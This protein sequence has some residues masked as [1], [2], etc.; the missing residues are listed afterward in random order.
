[1]G[2]RTGINWK[3]KNKQMHKWGGVN[4]YKKDPSNGG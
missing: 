3:R 1:M 2:E 4:K